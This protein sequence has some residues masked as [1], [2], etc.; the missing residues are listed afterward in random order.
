[1]DLCLF[2]AN[3]V[4]TERGKKKIMNKKMTFDDEKHLIGTTIEGRCMQNLQGQKMWKETLSSLS[5]AEAENDITLCC[6]SSRTCSKKSFL[7][8]ALQHK[9]CTIIITDGLR[10]FTTTSIIN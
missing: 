9:K 8:P 2:R 4:S 5:R 7:A 1:M 10:H 3:K 6:S